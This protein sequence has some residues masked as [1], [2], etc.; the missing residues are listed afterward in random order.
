MASKLIQ[1]GEF[2]IQSGQ[3]LDNFYYITEGKIQALFPGGF[4]TL[5]KGDIIGI[6]DFNQD[7]HF[8]SYKAETDS[9]VVP[10]GSPAVLIRT[11]FFAEHPD[12]M[13]FVAHAMNRFIK[14]LLQKYSSVYS[15]C[16]DLYQFLIASYKQYQSLCGELHVVMKGLPA[17]NLLEPLDEGYAPVAWQLP[18]YTGLY[19]FFSDKALVPSLQQNRFIPGYLYHAS[20]DIHT[21]FQKLQEISDYSA[22]I[23]NLL[24]NEERVDLFDLYTGLYYRI[25]IQLPQ[26][27]PKGEAITNAIDSICSHVKNHPAIPQSLAESRLEEYQNQLNNIRT[28]AEH[29]SMDVTHAEFGADYSLPGK[30]ADSLGIILEYADCLDEV[31]ASFRNSLAA[32]KQL[33]DKNATTPAAMRLRENLARNFYQVY[34]AAFRSASGI[35]TSPLS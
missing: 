9:R 10:Y 1:A 24:L 26:G 14:A 13:M 32:Y 20:G 5:G 2:F 33:E 15:E 18:Y 22:E 19:N 21:L 35:T 8:L 7:S 25:G 16:K 29:P 11:K 28:M 4:I 23:S 3:P 6:C 31:N 30:L 12:N 27:D 34:S 17:F